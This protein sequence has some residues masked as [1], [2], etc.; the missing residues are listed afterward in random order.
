MGADIVLPMVSPAFFNLE[1]EDA[2]C[3]RERERER[4]SES[5]EERE[6]EGDRDRKSI[7]FWFLV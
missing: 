3:P 1:F 4:E 5:V 7:P 2:R 6:G